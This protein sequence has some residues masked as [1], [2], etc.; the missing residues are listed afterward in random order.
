MAREAVRSRSKRCV[1]FPL[2]YRALR[3]PPAG[4]GSLA[5]ELEVPEDVVVSEAEFGSDMVVRQAVWLI[6]P[7]LPAGTPAAP[8]AL[9]PN[10]GP[11][12]F[13]P[14]SVGSTP[15]QLPTQVPVRLPATPVNSAK[16]LQ[17]VG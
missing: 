3:R 2:R 14:C 15:T 17:I 9:T 1:W 13:S 5:V 10:Q 7:L 8:A 11:N 16:K 4:E 6:G 12:P